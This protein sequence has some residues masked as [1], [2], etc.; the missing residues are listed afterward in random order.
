MGT[1]ILFLKWYF[2]IGV[3][4][5]IFLKTKKG[6]DLHHIVT[7]IEDKFYDVN[8]EASKQKYVEYVNTHNSITLEE[9]DIEMK[10]VDFFEIL[11]CSDKYNIDPNYGES[12]ETQNMY[13]IK[14]AIEEKYLKD[15][16]ERG[17]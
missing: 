13:R 14:R 15:K 1:Y 8:G 6:Y 12:L 7:K 5:G 10:E 2:Q 16:G 9:D 17:E 4:V 11:R 3:P